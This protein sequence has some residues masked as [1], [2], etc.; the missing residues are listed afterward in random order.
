MPRISSRSSV[1]SL[2]YSV[3]QAPRISRRGVNECADE[4]LRDA[5]R[6]G[7]PII[8]DQALSKALDQVRTLDEIPEELYGPVAGYLIE[9]KLT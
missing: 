2:E 4:I 8:V 5:R 9:L 3:N 7:V 6:Y 1:V